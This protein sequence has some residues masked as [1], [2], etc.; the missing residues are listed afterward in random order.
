MGKTFDSIEFVNHLAKQLIEKFDFVSKA[1]TPVLVGNSREN[2]VRRKFENILPPIVGVGSGCVIDSYE[3]CSSQT[4]IVIYEKYISQKF[5]I[6][7]TPDTTYFPCEGVAAVGEVKSLLGKKELEDSFEKIKSVKKLRRRFPSSTDGLCGPSIP[8]RKYGSSAVI[9]G[10]PEESYDQKNKITDQIFGFI[11]CG[12]LQ[13]KPE[14]LLG[15]FNNLCMSE[16]ENILPNILVSLKNGVCVF[17]NKDK[18][19]VCSSKKD[20]TGTYFVSHPGGNFQYLLYELHNVILSGRTVERKSMNRYIF[21]KENWPR[22]GI[23]S[24]FSAQP[25]A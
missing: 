21:R 15:H 7:D 6:N 19:A 3:V 11:L 2:E 25:D 17:L 10:T 16:E 14:T 13:I 8:Y 22:I 20:S 5:S 9:Q 4:D 24:E 23:Y 18:G 1:T 12:K